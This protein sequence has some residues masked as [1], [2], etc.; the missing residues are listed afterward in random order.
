MRSG[1]GQPM[2]EW[3]IAAC[4]PRGGALVQLTTGKGRGD[5]QRFDEKRGF[6]ASHESNRIIFWCCGAR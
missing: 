2:L 5:A 3:A 4:P 6:V 1:I